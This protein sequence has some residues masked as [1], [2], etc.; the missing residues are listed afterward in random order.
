MTTPKEIR[1][2]GVAN[3]L[4]KA[5]RG[6]ISAECRAAYHAAHPSSDPTYEDGSED[7][8]LPFEE[9]KPEV[10][11]LPPPPRVAVRKETLAYSI[12]SGGAMV[13]HDD[14]GTC[15]NLIQ[16]CACQDGP[17]ALKWVRK[18]VEQKPYLVEA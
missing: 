17:D 18:E 2:W 6:R 14:C 5:S 3:G 13:G 9:L 10:E 8:P 7:V 12:T 1:E 15:H 16:Y 4:A 11:Y